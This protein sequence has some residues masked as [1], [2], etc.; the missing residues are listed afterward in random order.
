MISSFLFSK[1]VVVIRWKLGKSFFSLILVVMMCSK[2]AIFNCE[3][4]LGKDGPTILHLF[5][6][7]V[8]GLIFCVYFWGLILGLDFRLYFWEM[9]ANVRDIFNFICG[10]KLKGSKTLIFWAHDI[11]IN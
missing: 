1:D 7:L 10:L 2:E 4:C 5:W 3:R 8:F 11:V 6:G 9:H